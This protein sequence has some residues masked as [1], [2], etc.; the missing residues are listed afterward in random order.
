MRTVIGVDA[1]GT[2]TKAVLVDETGCRRGAG[3]SGPGNPTSAGLMRASAHLAEA[4]LTAWAHRDGPLDPP[5]YVVITAAGVASDALLQRVSDDVAAGGLTCPVVVLSDALGAWFSAATETEGAVLIVGTGT[6]AGRIEGGELARTADGLGWLLGDGGSG[7]WVGREVARAVAADLDGHG[8]PTTLTAAV[9]DQ[10]GTTTLGDVRTT[11]PWR[12]PRLVEL[13][14]WVYRQPPVQLA[15]FAPL[16]F[17]AAAAGDEVAGEIVAGSVAQVLHRAAQVIDD[18]G[19]PV[20]LT[21]GLLGKDSPLTA[22]LHE[23]WPGRCRRAADGTA[24]AAI[25][26]LRH[27]GLPA[28]PAELARV[29]SGV[30]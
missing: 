7:F 26:A 23:R 5:G 13:V 6:T 11:I 20:V 21:G 30:C 4:A 24:G 29:R 10:L 14:A 3:R 17:S 28:G 2:S 16:A 1:G 9:L 12:N 27:L 15:A 19:T 8:T 25:L 22:A 18:A